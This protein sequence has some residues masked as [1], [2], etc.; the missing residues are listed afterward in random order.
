MLEKRQNWRTGGKGCVPV[1]ST[2]AVFTCDVYQVRVWMMSLSAGNRFKIF[3]SPV[4]MS[5]HEDYS[6]HHRFSAKDAHRRSFPQ[7]R[8]KG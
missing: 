2:R 3:D 5:R 7:N 8:K 1:S 6:P 4:E